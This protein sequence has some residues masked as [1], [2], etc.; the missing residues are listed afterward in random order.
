VATP[1]ASEPAGPA[2]IRSDAA[3]EVI[4][5]LYFEL[6]PAEPDLVPITP[7]S[8]L[9][10]DLGLDSLARVELL[11]RLEQSLGVHLPEATLGTMET[12]ADVL[13]ALQIAG[14]AA[15]A[16][17]GA[18]AQAPALLRLTRRGLELPGSATTLNAVL[19]WRVQKDPDA[20][21]AVVLGDREP[22][23]LTYAQLR[24]GAQTVASGLIHAGVQPRST[25]ALMLPTGAGYLHAFL[26]TLLADA[27]PVPIYPPA[28]PSQLEEHVQRHAG[29]LANAGADTLVTVPEAR[30]VGRLLRARVPSLRNVLS[31]EELELA[32]YPSIPRHAP[33]GDS[34]AMLQYTSGSTGAPKGVILTHAN[35]LANIRAMGRAVQATEA[36]VF[37]SWLPLYHDMGLI[38]A[39][40]GCLYF[41][42]VFV[43]MPPTSFL[44]RPACWLRAIHDYRATLSASPNFG[45]ELCAR[46]VSDRDLE[47]LDLSSWRV[48]FNGAEPVYRETLERFAQRFAP[49]GFRRQ[50]L[51]PVYGLAE[52]AVGLTFP[53]I[54]RGPLADCIDR[55]RMMD[56]GE[57]V[58]VAED[59]PH[60][61]RFVSCGQPLPG[62]QLRIVDAGGVEVPE[63]IEGAVQF[64][65]PSATQGY[66]RNPTETARLLHGPWLDTGDRG[67]VA[68]GELYVTGRVKDIV[69]RRGRH[70]YPDEVEQ[71]V[72]ELEGVRKGC[73]AAFGAREPSGA[74]EKLVVLAETRA[75]DPVSL[76]K[77]KGRIN[78]CVVDCIGE[79]PEEVLLVRPHTVLKTSSGKLRRAATRAAYEDGSLG[80]ATAS[81]A[82]QWLRLAAGSVRPR[83][84]RLRAQFLRIAY[85]SYA[86]LVVLGFAPAV[87]L[88]TLVLPRRRS[89]SV[90]HRAA[91]WLVRACRIPLSVVWEPEADL[92]MPHVI[93]TNHCSYVDSIILAAVLREPHAFVAKTEL[94]RV[95]LLGRWLRRIGTVFIERFVPEQ[96]PAEV[97]RLGQ[98]LARGRSLVMFAEGTFT[99]VTGLAPFHLGAFQ[100]AVACGTPLVPVTIRGTR[101]VLRDGQWLL[102][103]LPVAVVVGSPLVGLPDTDRFAE[104][105]RLRDLAREH[106]LGRCGEPDLL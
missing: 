8:S 14:T 70:I 86:W 92:P 39:W 31:I 43:V 91:R 24:E 79:P 22:E 17:S 75:T 16:E 18:R 50:A 72:G 82:L 105:V 28:R 36:D 95:P 98:E 26:G 45:Y 84:R 57:A 68:R 78:E 74:T 67:Y 1:L 37:V 48:A 90:V 13:R 47:G 106:I 71:A 76:A 7:E 53:P 64:S 6:H 94:Q 93:V 56:A 49:R 23:L 62:Y 102:R 3:L 44:A 88:L 4:R 77:L 30:A 54:N 12:V 38:G 100:A 81:P 69:I 65:G 25:V 97:E 85:G 29:I 99:R 101:S 46:R 83:L 103:R 96:S 10:E 80:H 15:P 58:P 34:V 104:A 66:Y 40:L 20:T 73:V 87:G 42:C 2:R 59:H 61:L 41:G 5:R 89:W 55:S 32:R 27:I 52:A 63:R 60:A 21:H 51:T 19:D 33:G 35:L 9:E 11:M